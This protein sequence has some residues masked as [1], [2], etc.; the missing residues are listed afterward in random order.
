MFVVLWLTMGDGREER[1]FSE[2]L[3]D[4]G[5]ALSQAAFESRWLMLCMTAMPALARVTAV[6][7]SGF[8]DC[9]GLF[10]HCLGLQLDILQRPS[11]M[12]GEVPSSATSE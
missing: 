5:C 10:C 12:M 2:H 7:L 1:D 11:R 9:R 8:A 3:Q 6:V 4:H